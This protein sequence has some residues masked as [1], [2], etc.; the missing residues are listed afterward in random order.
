MVRTHYEPT[1][2]VMRCKKLHLQTLLISSEKPYLCKKSQ[3]MNN[4]SKQ[5]WSKITLEDN[6][7]ALKKSSKWK[8]PGKD[9]TPNFWL[10]A[11]HET[12]T[13][14]I[15]HFILVINDSK[16]IGIWVVNGN[17]Y[18][19]PKSDET[20]NPKNYFILAARWQCTKS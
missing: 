4:W 13:R 1:T 8:S 14:L 6:K 12:H 16:Q 18:L 17:N 11:F 10:N 19:L 20:N 15:Q 5:E 9:K 3:T 7:H 2:L